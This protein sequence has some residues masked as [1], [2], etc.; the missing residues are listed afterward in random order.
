MTH[1]F[2]IHP[3]A[4]PLG[5]EISG[6]GAE[7]NLPDTVPH[8]LRDALSTHLVLVFREQSLSPGA[9]L[10]FA[11]LFGEPVT[12]QF[13]Q[14]MPGHGQVTE[15]RKE[16]DHLHNFGGAWH[17]D[18][19]FMAQPPSATVLMAKE[20]PV[21]GGDTLWSNQHLAY[22]TLPASCRDGI[23]S[24]VAEHT[25]QLAFGDGAHALSAVHP[26]AP[27]HPRSG[28][29]YLY[30]NPV[31]IRRVVGVADEAGDTLL[32]YLYAHA[33]A[34]EFQYRHR[35]KPGDIV[36]WDNRATM[37]RAMNDYAGERR[38]MQ[39]VAVTDLQG[40]ADLS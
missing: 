9:L 1:A 5:A 32:S 28:C 22:A 29:R 23:N 10:E 36:V 7:G 4:G 37:H 17:F 20:L 33:I 31:S 21:D 16:P 35:W 19:S 26:L 12:H 13:V 27:M 3:F 24:L 2:R 34:P 40:A 11:A 39:R 38:V 15:I 14:A 18:L 25:S 30:A 8:S 6:L